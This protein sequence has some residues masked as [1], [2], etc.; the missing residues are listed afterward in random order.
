MDVIKSFAE[1]VIEGV[2][3][4]SIVIMACHVADAAGEGRSYIGPRG[5][6]HD[7]SPLER[8]RG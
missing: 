6:A 1:G 4:L 7:A 3:M 5:D 8:R 2:L